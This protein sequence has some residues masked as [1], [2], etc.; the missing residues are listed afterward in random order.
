[1]DI[2]T[3]HG[4]LALKCERLII[5][6]GDVL[7][8]TVISGQ[9]NYGGGG[10]CRSGTLGVI[11]VPEGW[12]AGLYAQLLTVQLVCEHGQVNVFR[13][14]LR[15]AKQQGRLYACEIVGEH[16]LYKDAPADTIAFQVLGGIV[17]GEAPDAHTV[18][19]QASVWL[20]AIPDAEYG[21]L[22]NGTDVLSRFGGPDA[23][24]VSR[25][26]LGAR[27][28]EL[29]NLGY[30][31]PNYVTDWYWTPGNYS[32]SLAGVN[33]ERP[34]R[35]YSGSRAVPALTPRRTAEA[36]ADPPLVTG[37]MPLE[38]Q[39]DT[40]NPGQ[41]IAYGPDVLKQINYTILFDGV[42]RGYAEHDS[43]GTS[44]TV[45]GASFFANVPPSDDTH[46]I[47]KITLSFPFSVTTPSGV[48]PFVASYTTADDG[49]T[50][51][52]SMACT[53]TTTARPAHLA[54]P[55]SR[56]RWTFTAPPPAPG[57]SRWAIAPWGC[58]RRPPLRSPAAWPKLRI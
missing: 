1:M 46:Q 52:R 9:F 56:P 38:L 34:W 51:G 36:S 44:Y 22:P 14:V 55:A 53:P 49:T 32:L 39:Q 8:A 18:D 23:V 57:R 10:T 26:A 45:D 21:R 35:H 30:A 6:A 2:D 40:A 24:H 15:E 54:T 50:P 37:S 13:G 11:D 48:S 25:A 31:E 47:Q 29:S 17:Q 58:N 42:T 33:E 41:T 12:L 20:A 28:G 7:G 16:E 4:F 5:A 19:E 3:G 43:D 27:A